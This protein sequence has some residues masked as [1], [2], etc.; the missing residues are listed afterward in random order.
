[1]KVFGNSALLK[2]SP[3][4]DERTPTVEECLR[5]AL[6]NEA[7][8]M[9]LTGV[10]SP[11]EIEENVSIANNYEPL[12]EAEREDLDEFGK[13]LG[14]GYCY[15]C[16]YCMPCPAEINIPGILGLLDYQKRISWEWP[17][18]RQQYAEFDKTIDDCLDCKQCEEAC[19]Q[20]LPVRELLA[21]AKERLGQP[22]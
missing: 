18:G 3:V 21:E 16:N 11:E 20:S 10:K 7:F 14:Q 8:P 9:I 1:M 15:G 6:S 13:R 12:T 5:F 2:L 17:Q 19:P 22:V 4:D